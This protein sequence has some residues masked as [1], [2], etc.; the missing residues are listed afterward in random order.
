MVALR[1]AFHGFPCPGGFES[2]YITLFTP[3]I[4]ATS[5]GVIRIS[6]LPIQLPAAPYVLNAMLPCHV[7]KLSAPSLEILVTGVRLSPA[8]EV[9]MKLSLGVGLKMKAPFNSC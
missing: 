1:F 3:M 8:L 7:M 2:D 9:V 6:F 5:W 4:F